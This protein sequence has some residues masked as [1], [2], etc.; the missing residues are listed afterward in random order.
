[1]ELE[2]REGRV[3]RFL[4]HGVRKNIAAVHGAEARTAPSPWDKMRELASRSA[5]RTD[6]R[7]APEW[8][9]GEDRVGATVLV[10]P[11]SRDAEHFHRVIRK[12]V[13]YRLALGQPRPH[14]LVEALEANLSHERAE[15]L[16]PQ[17]K[18]D[19]SPKPNSQGG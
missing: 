17:L 12:R 19:L 18:L 15:E 7:F 5:A 13:F 2:Q 3:R 16:L 1:M 14:E 10:P 8:V 6:K 11:F 4:S 9:Y